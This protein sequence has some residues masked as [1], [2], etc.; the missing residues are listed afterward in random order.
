MSRPATDAM[1]ASVAAASARVGGPYAT[2]GLSRDAS[3][4]DVR[5]AYRRAALALHPDKNSAPGAAEQFRRAARAFETLGDARRRREY[6]LIGAGGFFGSG[7]LTDEEEEEDAPAWDQ[8]AFDAAP[9]KVKLQAFGILLLVL[10]IRFFLWAV[11]WALSFLISGGRLVLRLVVIL[12]AV[13][14]VAVDYSYRFVCWV[15]RISYEGLHLA[16]AGIALSVLEGVRRTHEAIHPPI[17]QT[18]LHT[19]YE[20]AVETT[21]PSKTRKVLRK[22][23]FRSKRRDR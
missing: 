17:R 4:D 23:R 7:D 3:A 12:L 5:R 19:V 22:M 14:F 9:L 20:P 16:M 21:E 8:E 2:L 1:R 18:E 6:D 10:S 15:G 11:V 13:T